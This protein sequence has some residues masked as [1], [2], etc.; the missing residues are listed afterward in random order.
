VP[1]CRE[2]RPVSTVELRKPLPEGVF[3]LLTADDDLAS[4]YGSLVAVCGEVLSTSALPP[5]CFPPG[6][7]LDRDPLYCPA[8][9]RV[10]V[11]W[12][13]DGDRASETVDQVAMR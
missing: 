7:E 11:R 8:C 9:I 6:V 4:P 2:W 3:H 10:A 1:A 12:S 13:S 5:S